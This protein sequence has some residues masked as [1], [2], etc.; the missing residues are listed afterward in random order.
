MGKVQYPVHRG[1]IEVNRVGNLSR[2]PKQSIIS[3]PP[4]IKNWGHTDAKE[5]V[6]LTW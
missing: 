3:P 5:S 4:N 1:E 6:W 2:H